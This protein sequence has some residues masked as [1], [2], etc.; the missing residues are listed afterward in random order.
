MQG[1]GSDSDQACVGAAWGVRLAVQQQGGCVPRGLRATMLGAR[2][3]CP[4]FFFFP[5]SEMTW[6]ASG[7]FS[8]TLIVGHATSVF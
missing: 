7:A 4:L 1:P 3:Q 8:Q 2:L 5:T 6:A